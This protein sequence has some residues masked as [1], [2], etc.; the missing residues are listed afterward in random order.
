MEKQ[1]QLLTAPNNYARCLNTA[2]PQAENC[3]RRIASLQDTDEKTY[4]KVVNP[5]RYPE[6]GENCP[7]FRSAEKI[8]AAWGVTHL[9]DNVP[10]KEAALVRALVINYFGKS[11]YYR[12]FR[13]EQFIT[14]EQQSAIRHIFRQRGIA[15]EPQFDYYTLEYNW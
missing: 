13:K 3:L 1:P 11:R 14:P 10:Y 5:L 2:C 7:L 9:L 6:E 12:C 8:H 4:L 15:D